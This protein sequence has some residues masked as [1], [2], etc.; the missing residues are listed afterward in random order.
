MIRFSRFH[1]G[2]KVR[3]S[4]L[5]FEIFWEKDRAGTVKVKYRTAPKKLQGACRRIK[6]W[7]GL[8]LTSPSGYAPNSYQIDIM[9]ESKYLTTITSKYSITRGNKACLAL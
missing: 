1:P 4:F 2:M 8:V 9:I 7:M 3:I 6:E 5:G